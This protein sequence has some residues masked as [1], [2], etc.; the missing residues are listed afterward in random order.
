[1]GV[2]KVWIFR[3]WRLQCCWSDKAAWEEPHQ[4]L[5]NH[6][7]RLYHLLRPLVWPSSPLSQFSWNQNIS[8]KDICR[9]FLSVLD[10]IPA[11]FDQPPSQ[12]VLKR[13]KNAIFQE[14]QKWQ[15]A[16][17]LLFRCLKVWYHHIVADLDQFTWWLT[18]WLGCR[19]VST[20]SYTASLI[21]Y[22]MMAMHYRLRWSIG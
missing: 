18:F 12:W 21:G 8:D 11:P 20:L 19:P 5:L 2:M 16:L 4:N 13:A 1:M 14:C 3:C 22:V 7:R 9:C 15:I 10:P 6:L 17:N